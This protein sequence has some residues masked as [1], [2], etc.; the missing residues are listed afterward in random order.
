MRSSLKILSAVFLFLP[1]AAALAQVQV[2]D[3]WIRATVPAQKSSGAF[4]KLAAAQDA[5][6][7][8]VSS[9]VAGTAE[10]HE[11]AMS[12]NVMRMRPVKGVDIPAGGGAELKPGGFHVMLLDLKR[13]LKAGES[14]PMTLVFES[15][16]K[17]R[18]TIEVRATVMP[19]AASGPAATPANHEMKH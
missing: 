14:V 2:S 9:P 13:Q 17:K 18:Q 8:A 11:M 5:R 10:L 1:C 12:N 6:L 15:A 4:M 7:V 16:D 3:A 19:I